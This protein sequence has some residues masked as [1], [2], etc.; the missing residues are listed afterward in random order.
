ME[1]SHMLT[2]SGLISRNLCNKIIKIKKAD[3]TKLEEHIA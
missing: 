3:V 2:R 1:L